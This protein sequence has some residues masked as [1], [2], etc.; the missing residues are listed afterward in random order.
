M[1]VETCKNNDFNVLPIFG[2]VQK[3]LTVDTTL[4]HEQSKEPSFGTSEANYSPFHKK[5]CIVLD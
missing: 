5:C 4:G 2:S 1:I 3:V